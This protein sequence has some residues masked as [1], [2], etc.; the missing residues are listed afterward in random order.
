V[1]DGSPGLILRQPFHPLQFIEDMIDVIIHQ[2]FVLGRVRN[3]AEFDQVQVIE[4]VF[5]HHAGRANVVPLCLQESINSL[6]TVHS[7]AV[8]QIGEPEIPLL[9]AEPGEHRLQRVDPLADIRYELL[10]AQLV[11][12]LTRP[13]QVTERMPA[14]EPPAQDVKRSLDL[15][16]DHKSSRFDFMLFQ[17]VKKKVIDR[18]TVDLAKRSGGREFVESQADLFLGFTVGQSS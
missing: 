6:A 4:I 3:L 12:V 13:G 7:I 9:L 11:V 15:L 18:L 1:F 14:V 16:A 2:Q 5:R 8:M 10:R 17:G